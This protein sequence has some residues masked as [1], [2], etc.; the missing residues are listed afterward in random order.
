MC[1]AAHEPRGHRQERHIRREST[2]CTA[3]VYATLGPHWGHTG[4][5]LGP[6]WGHTGAFNAGDSM[7]VEAFS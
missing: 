4:A 3:Q 7:E 6:H 1:E 5:T 2:L